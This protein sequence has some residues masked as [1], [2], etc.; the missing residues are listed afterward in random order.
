MSYSEIVDEIQGDD[1]KAFIMIAE[2]AEAQK[3][4]IC[5]LIELEKKMKAIEFEINTSK[6]DLNH[7][8]QYM[9]LEPPFS[10]IVNNSVCNLEEDFE[11]K[12]T[13]A[14]FNIKTEE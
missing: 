13:Q 9:K 12:I 14:I 10:I 3:I 8:C 7:I 5:N 4:R 6:R 1:E 2:I 11:T